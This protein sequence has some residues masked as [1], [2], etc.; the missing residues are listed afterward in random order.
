MHGG[1]GIGR[2]AARDVAGWVPPLARLG[3]AAKGVVYVLVGAIAVRA[4]TATG[5]PEGTTGALRSLTDESGGRTMLAA[6]A[7]GLAAH[8]VWRLVQAALDPEHVRSDAK[9]AGMRV[10]YALSAVIYGALAWTAWQL[11]RGGRGGEGDGGSWVAR[12]MELPAGRWLVVAAGVGVVVY[13]LHQLV[14][15][16]KGDVM[17]RLGKSSRRLRALGRFG[18]G[19]RGLVLLPVGWFLVQAGR[20][21]DPGA[22]GGTE[23]A[24]GMLDKGAP[25]ALVGLGLLAYGVFQIA[26]AAFRRI[27]AP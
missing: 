8:V 18:V 15:A 22:A 2:E 24:L 3:Y 19:A 14:Q 9:R 4:A 26:K 21:Y 16:A 17:H 27:D 1:N 23:R 11:A 5:T 12:L 13:G 7:I 20:H 6:I 10:F 25:L